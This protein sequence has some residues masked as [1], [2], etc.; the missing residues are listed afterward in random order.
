[1]RVGSF[2]LLSCVVGVAVVGLLGWGTSSFLVSETRSQTD[3]VQLVNYDMS[4]SKMSAVRWAQ[5]NHT[6][7]LLADR[8]I[9]SILTVTAITEPPYPNALIGVYFSP[10][11]FK[12]PRLVDGDLE[13]TGA[14]HHDQTVV[15]RA[16]FELDED[17]KY[18]IG[19]KAVS[20]LG[21]AEEGLGAVYYLEVGNGM[22]VKVTDQNGDVPPSV[23]MESKS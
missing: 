8:R 21:L 9:E 15:V 20:Y 12:V 10:P 6:I 13:W 19:S 23:S 3:F 17:G 2:L 22:I 14:I 16:V 4:G 1:M 5:I 18:F 7:V 11:G